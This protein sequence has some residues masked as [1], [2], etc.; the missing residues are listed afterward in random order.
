M[1]K[2][3]VAK[4][5]QVTVPFSESETERNY[6]P[7]R[8]HAYKPHLHLPWWKGHM[9]LYQ[10]ALDCP[11]GSVRHLHP[12]PASHPVTEPAKGWLSWGPDEHQLVDRHIY[13]E[14]N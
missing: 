8:V 13:S 3:C 1:V 12:R 2:P 5:A 7:T 9:V 4:E 6:I 14:V 11:P 10:N